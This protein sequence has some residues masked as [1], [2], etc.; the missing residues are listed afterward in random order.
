L[1][2]M[3]TAAAALRDEGAPHAASGLPLEIE[4]KFLLTACPPAA[5]T[6]DAVRIE[7]GWI[8]GTALR[9]RLRRKIM[10][11]GRVECWRT[12][13][14]GPSQARVEVE[15]LA[16]PPLFDAMW[17]LTR[18]ARITKDR[19]A[20]LDGAHTWEIDVFAGR[21]LVLAEVELGSEDETV[22]IPAWLAP[23]VER[24]VTSEPQYLNSNLAQPE[25]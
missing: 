24:E 3:R 21:D 19:Y 5:R 15:E 10:T 12:V 20:V 6:V 22:T 23:Y 16:A 1:Q 14:L 2:V 13:K 11:D 9:E 7:Q 17:P 25:P 8:P 4:R 18:P